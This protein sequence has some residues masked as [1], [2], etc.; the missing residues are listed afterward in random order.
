MSETVIT[1]PYCGKKIQLTEAITHQIEERLRRDFAQETKKKEKDFENQLKEKDKEL[2]E[3]LLQE[4]HKLEK[5]A[6][7]KAEE[8]LST[9]IRD[10]KEQL[11]EKARLVEEAHTHELALRKRTRELEEKEKTLNL[12]VQRTLD[13]ERPKIWQEAQ[14]KL[15]EQKMDLAPA[16]T[17]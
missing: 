3:T 16:V 15:R 12:D 8:A 4:K 9:E 13:K 17:T 6:K 11:E 14:E 10:L 2:E 5:Q 7:K 1:C